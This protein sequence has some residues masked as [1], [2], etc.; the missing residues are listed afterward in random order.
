MAERIGYRTAQHNSHRPTQRHTSRHSTRHG[1]LVSA[2]EC[3]VGDEREEAELP[4]ESERAGVAYHV[5]H[6]RHHQQDAQRED[7]S[8]RIPNEEVSLL[9]AQEA[10]GRV[11]HKLDAPG[12]EALDGGDERIA[13]GCAQL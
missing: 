9:A 13:L 1:T 6:D 10:R 3:V 5:V 12:L 11:L 7:R 2:Y 4:P 8:H